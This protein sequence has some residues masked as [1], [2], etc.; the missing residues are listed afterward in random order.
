MGR[1]IAAPQVGLRRRAAG[2]S[3]RC[4]T[5]SCTGTRLPRQ[6]ANTLGAVPCRRSRS[7]AQTLRSTA[8]PRC[9]PGLFVCLLACLLFPASSA[10]DPSHIDPPSSRTCRACAHICAGTCAPHLRQD[11]SPHLR[12]TRLQVRGHVGRRRRTCGRE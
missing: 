8:A 1:Q 10:P 12:G 9:A 7:G 11:L 2:R 3:I 5:V 6:L 4:A